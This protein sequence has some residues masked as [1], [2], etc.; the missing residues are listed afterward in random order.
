MP[1]K[2]KPRDGSLQFW[3]RKRARSIYPSISNYP[4]SSENKPLAFMGYKAGMTRVEMKETH[5]GSPTQGQII[6]VPVTVI[7]IPPL[8]ILGARAYSYYEN[9]FKTLYDIYA[10]K[11]QIP[12]KYR[13]LNIN[14]N[15]KLDDVKIEELDEIRLLAASQPDKTGIGKKN[16]EKFE[17]GIG[18]NVEKQFEFL[19]EN[20]GKEI[21]IGDVFEEGDYVDVIGITKG[22]GFQG[23]VKRYGV[24]V[25]GRKDEQ[26]HRQIGVI[27]TEGEGR[28]KYTVPQPGQMGFHRRCEYNKR[29]LK[30]GTDSEKINPNGD[31]KRY[32]TVKNDY[33]ILKGSVPGN[34]KRPIFLRKSIRKH[35]KKY[36]IEL[37]EIK[38]E[39]QQGV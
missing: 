4:K 7:E 26:H 37:K 23:V 2:K 5:K 17:I 36:P 3:P 39:S 34:K 11:D 24:K 29:I 1:E 9:S 12:K 33:V 6:P 8:F 27:G 28:V 10:P 22:K 32:G 31:F 16:S 14:Y 13:K 15:K 35:K 38:K 25:R 20:L 30:V 21:R 19:K 18:G